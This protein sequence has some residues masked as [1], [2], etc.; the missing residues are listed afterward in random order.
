MSK[1]AFVVNVHRPYEGEID[2]TDAFIDYD[3]IVGDRRLPSDTDTPIV[4]YCE[5]GRMSA[6]AADA[7]V[8]VGY[9][10]VAHLEGGIVAWEA[11]DMPVFRQQSD[12]KSVVSGKSVSVRVD[13]GGRRILKKKKKK[14]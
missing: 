12:R 1:G 7:L 4:L 8:R 11:A 9:T 6:I 5:T 10:D 14:Q 2:G 13:L 3:E